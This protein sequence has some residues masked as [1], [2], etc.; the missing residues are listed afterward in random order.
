MKGDVH[1][2]I[3]H[4]MRRPRQDSFSIE[5][6]Y[7]DIRGA[8]PADCLFSTWTCAYFSQ[9]I[10]GRLLDVWNASFAQRDVNHVTG[11]VHY[12]T[13]LLSHHKTVLTIHDL[14]MLSRLRGVRRWLLWLLWYWIPIRQS[15]AVIVISATT[16]DQLLASVRCNP[17]KIHVIHNPVSAEFKPMPLKFNA[18]RPRI[19][20]V[21]TGLN[22]NLERVAEALSGVPC[23]LAII[24]H[25]SPDQLNLLETLHVDY[26]NHANL[27]RAQLLEQYQ[28]ADMLV[29]ASTYEGFGLPIVEANAVGRPVITSNVF[30]MPEVAGNAACFVDPY[31]P[32]AIRAAVVRVTE[33][34]EYR[35]ALIEAGFRNVERFRLHTI[36]EQYAAIYR[37]VA[38]NSSPSNASLL[39]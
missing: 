30:S 34:S 39:P 10:W 18:E 2:N 23:R 28:N 21:G 9:G 17:D 27:T 16:R 14:V 15:R 19:L 7:E 24:G 13:Y 33:D 36:A 1:L 29:F 8:S 31:S 35:A 11:D 26:E 38:W 4:F 37:A 3:V 32:A 5:R 25:L 20:Q 22:K 6:L 12:L